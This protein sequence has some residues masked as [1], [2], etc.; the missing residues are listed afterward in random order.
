MDNSHEVYNSFHLKGSVL[1]SYLDRDEWYGWNRHYKWIDGYL[2]LYVGDLPDNHQHS[3]W[4]FMNDTNIRFIFEQI[5]YDN[6]VVIKNYFDKITVANFE[7]L[8]G[9]YVEIMGYIEILFGETNEVSLIAT[10]I[11]VL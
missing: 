10:S 2:Q 6:Q 5:H 11:N 7:D 8:K 4:G 1:S 9:K 3:D